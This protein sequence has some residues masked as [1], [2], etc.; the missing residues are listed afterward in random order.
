MA[1]SSSSTKSSPSDKPLDTAARTEKSDETSN[2]PDESSNTTSP[3]KTAPEDDN[4]QQQTSASPAAAAAAAA[5][6]LPTYESVEGSKRYLVAKTL[7]SEG[8]FEAAMMTIEEG[9]EEIK[10]QLLA[11]G[12]M[13]E[14]AVGVH[15]AMGPFHYLYGTTLLYSV[16]ESTDDL[17]QQQ[18]VNVPGGEEGGPNGQGGGS[19]GYDNDYE[20]PPADD[21]QI[22]FENLDIA[23]VI[24]EKYL[25]S[26]QSSCKSDKSGDSNINTHEVKSV[27]GLRLDLAQIRLREGDLNRL[28]GQHESAL[29]DYQECL[30]LRMAVVESK[31]SDLL[32]PYDRKLADVHYNLGLTYAMIV[33]EASTVGGD[34]DAAASAAAPAAAAAP[35]DSSPPKLDAQQL[36]NYRRCSSFHYLECGRIMCGRLAMLAQHSVDEF[37]QKVKAALPSFKTTGEDEED[38]RKD[39][40]GIAPAL[41]RLQLQILRQHAA[42]LPVHSA[43]APEMES[44]KDVLQE[45]QE[46]IDEA[47]ASEAGVQ[48]VAHMRAAI[49]AAAAAV[50]AEQDEASSSSNPFGAPAATTF[51]NPFGSQA[52]TAATVAAQP[53]M[54]VRKKKKRPPTESIDEK[55]GKQPKSSNE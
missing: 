13:S 11:D 33:A 8:D 24:L 15:P 17:Q 28:S 37:F 22:A 12:S 10:E 53:I 27:D 44:L 41:A 6:V 2:M 29:A 19:G 45:I 21:T 20:E 31:D 34:D 3:V 7:L 30:H 5:F 1:A 16:E 36:D 48:Q 54:A 49:A 9:L 47:E 18:T 26:L 32:G 40:K 14:D 23:R 42:E 51:T 25:E 39:T 55:D 43:D 50:G 38:N 46:T 35:A 52:A 4:N